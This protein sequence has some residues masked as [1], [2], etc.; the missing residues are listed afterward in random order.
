MDKKESGKRL[1]NVRIRNKMSQQAMAD[2]LGYASRSTI[3]EIEEGINEMS[4]DRIV[5]LMELY[6]L[7]RPDLG[8]V[9]ICGDKLSGLRKDAKYPN[10][11]IEE[12]CYIRNCVSNPN[13]V[14]VIIHIMTTKQVRTFLKSM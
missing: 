14:V 1:R 10:P 13:I 6:G 5:R 3:N 2:S 7:S 11:E 12:I 4:Y 9:P 8:L